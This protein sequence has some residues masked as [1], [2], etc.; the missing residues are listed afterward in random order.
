M[1]DVIEEV[2]YG[3]GKFILFRLFGV[4]CKDVHGIYSLPTELSLTGRGSS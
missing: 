1:L 2:T 3:E 4:K